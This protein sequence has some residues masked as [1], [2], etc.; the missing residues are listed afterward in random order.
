M[1]D[2]AVNDV[3]GAMQRVLV[4]ERAAEERL[5]AA[6]AEA[7]AISSRARDESRRIRSRTH[8]RISRLQKSFSEA[9]EAA[10][11]QLARTAAAVAQSGSADLDEA[12]LAAAVADLAARLSGGSDGSAA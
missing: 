8:Q 11:R 6:R 4:A 1:K 3:A 2:I 10:C 9:T 7:E 12:G 5:V